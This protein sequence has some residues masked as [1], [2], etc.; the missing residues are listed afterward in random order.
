MSEYE[1]ASM[2]ATAPLRPP[3]SENCEL[4]IEEL[5]ATEELPFDIPRD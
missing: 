2:M 4:T 1:P 3:N 5:A